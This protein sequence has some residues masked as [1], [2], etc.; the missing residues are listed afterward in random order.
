MPLSSILFVMAA[1]VIH[2]TWN[3]LAKR[4]AH[5][6]AA[7]VAAYG[8]VGFLAYAPWALW[9]ALHD[10]M[11]W[12]GPIIACIVASAL[13][14]LA[15]SLVL[16]HGY[17]AADLSVVYPVA[18]GTGP[19]LSALVA[20]VILGEQPGVLGLAGLVAVVGGI[21]LIATGGS[22][23][24]FRRADGRAGVAWGG[25][26]GGLIASYTVVDGY[27]VKALGIH[28]VLIDW[29]G[30]ALRLLLVLKVLT[31]DRAAARKAM[32]GH[33][34]AAV[35]VG[36]LAPLGYIFVLGALRAGAPISLVAPLRETSMML[37]AIF[38]MILLREPV[39]PGRLAGCAL[40]ALG[41]ALLA[42]A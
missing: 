23:R 21:L 27:G 18:R 41:A 34:P 37:A 31:G 20:I 30:N 39:G 6:G 33:W 7:F 38:G 2:A 16:Q 24:A 15:Y 3:L 22:L 5:V 11:R 17:R 25:A 29:F 4:A 40:I 9:V 32:R 1:A 13:I 26:T 10:G 8:L 35:A 19:L 28:P 12:S 42:S 14:H 36:L